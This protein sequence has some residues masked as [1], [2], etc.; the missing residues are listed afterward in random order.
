MPPD[1][2]LSHLEA[3]IDIYPETNDHEAVKR[4]LE[5]CQRILKSSRS[6][7]D[8]KI[9]RYNGFYSLTA[10]TNGTKNP[11]LLLQAHI[12]VVRDLSSP[13][14]IKS[15]GSVSGRGVY[16]MLF[17]VA[18]YLTFIES[19]T[20]ELNSLDLGLMITGDEEIGGFEGVRPLVDDGYIGQA[21]FLPDAGEG[22]GDL[23]VA[24]KGAYNFD[25][26]AT[27]IAHHGSRPWEGD[28]AANK[29][30]H[31]IHELM[32]EFDHSNW[33]NS[34]ITVTRFEGGGAI[35]RGPAEASAHID[36]RI[37]DKADYHIIQE[38]VA[39]ICKKYAGSI[40][41]ILATE[42][43]TI[44]T[45]DP[46]IQDFI[47]LYEKHSQKPITFSKAHGGSDARFFAAKGIPVILI[48]P[49]GSG[50]HSD[51]ETLDLK[52]LADFYNLLE[53]YILITAKIK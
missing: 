21:V 50:A 44:D 14:L 35:N 3:L 39:R 10:S 49:D 6:F 17:A 33:D 24:S 15:S 22:F 11:R 19:H 46:A 25:L 28:G 45:S 26:V 8:C 41:N 1:S 30:V 40:K 7:G 9:H 43:L 12:D 18:C 37:K 16:D 53:E 4:G 47:K 52:S 27:G 29:L 38:Q 34:T 51:E 32:A 31:M 2:V 23:S 20:N 5:Y 48:R 42:S 36:I 13:K